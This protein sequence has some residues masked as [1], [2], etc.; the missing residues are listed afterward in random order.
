MSETLG[1]KFDSGKVRMGLL[2]PLATEAIARVLTFGAQ[3]YAKDNW[4]KVDN[5]HDRYTDAAL[6]HVF[7]Y[8]KGEATDVETGE[9]HLAHALCCLMF[10]LDLDLQ[11]KSDN[12]DTE[13][14][15]EYLLKEPSTGP[16]VFNRIRDELNTYDGTKLQSEKP[17][18]KAF[19]NIRDALEQVSQYKPEQYATA[20]RTG[21]SEPG[22][23]PYTDPSNESQEPK[24]TIAA[25][26][27]ELWKYSFP[28]DS[29]PKY[30]TR[31]SK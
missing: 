14:Y 28:E 31:N 8:M 25:G 1:R 17:E 7:A 30:L 6:R 16:K 9:S 29:T 18:I 2:P 4:K 10:M 19:M 21:L 27:E 5:A 3:K 13:H 23:W 26:N 12:A 24:F 15:F 22:Q 11:R 20:S